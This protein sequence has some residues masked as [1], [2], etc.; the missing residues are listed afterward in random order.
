MDSSLPF[1]TAA[2]TEQPDRIGGRLL[3]EACQ[4]VPVRQPASQTTQPISGVL[5]DT[6]ECCRRTTVSGTPGGVRLEVDLPE[7]L[8]TDG[9]MLG[10]I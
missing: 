2:L 10:M 6:S 7:S 3:L 4:E 9:G 5:Q 8:L 1:V